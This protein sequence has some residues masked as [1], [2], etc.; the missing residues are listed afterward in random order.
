MSET[1]IPEPE[2]VSPPRR[3]WL[4]RILLGL[5]A[6][7][8]VIVGV[9]FYLDYAREGDLRE[10][11]ADADRLDPGWRF[12]DLEAARA[13]VPDAENGA[14]LVVTAGTRKPGAWPT[15]PGLEENLANLSPTERPGDADLKALRVELAKVPGGALDVARNLADRPR[16]RHAVAWTPDLIDT[17]MTHIQQTREVTGLLVLDAQLRAFDGDIEGALRSCR[18][19]LNAG[20]SI[21]DEPMLISQ[22]VRVSSTRQ[23]VRVLERILAQGEASPKSL[24]DFQRSLA[25]EAEEPLELIGARAERAS[26]YH[27]LGALRSGHVNRAS[28]GLRS[29]VLG[30]TGDQ[31]IDRSRARACQAPYLQYG[32]E[33]VEI[34]KLPTEQQQERLKAL[35][36]PSQQLPLLIEALTRGEDGPWTIQ[37]FHRSKAELRCAAAA[38]AAE[39]Y[40]LAK[41]HWPDRL[42]ALVPDYLAA[43]P[44]DPF[45]GRPLR[46]H[47]RADGI[48]IYSIGP[49]GTD[50]DGNLDRKNARTS[51]TDLGFQLWDLDRRGQAPASR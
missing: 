36:L 13:A 18:A 29:T 48:V 37:A 46:L 35:S 7:L 51:G 20:R 4:L 45:D 8:G 11:I 30:V 16:G 17:M 26:F 15:T 34:A 2:L 28:F 22:M 41:G 42:D 44:N 33:I 3:R 43:V 21:G 25:A 1:A 31:F 14:I 5:A 19:A 6:V 32:N 38:L 23:A 50:D 47:R 12:S 49:D 27:Y 39:R 10:A 24:E 40:R 9:Y